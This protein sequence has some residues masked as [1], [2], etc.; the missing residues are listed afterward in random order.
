MKVLKNYL[1]LF[2]LLFPWFHFGQEDVQKLKFHSMSLS[3]NFYSGNGNTGFMGNADLAVSLGNH[4]F[5][6]SAMAAAEIDICVWGTCYTDS[7]YSYDLM[8]GQ[9]F[10]AGKTIAIDLFAGAGFLHFETR[11]PDSRQKGYI[12]EKTIGFPLQ[13]RVRFRHGKVFNIG[14]QFHGNINSASSIIAVGPFFQ[15]NFHPE[16]SQN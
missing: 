16:K 8:Y 5:K 15:W 4:I 9:K 14:V 11:N 10:M 6:A 12:S 2:I 7:Y 1:F 13:G 3:P